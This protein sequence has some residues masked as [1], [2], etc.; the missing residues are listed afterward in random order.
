[1]SD[2]RISNVLTSEH[3]SALSLLEEVRDYMLRLPVVP[4]TRNLCVKISRH[5]ES[6]GATAIRKRSDDERG[7]VAY[8]AAGV[9]LLVANLSGQ[10]L[11]VKSP[12]AGALDEIESRRL[13]DMLTQGLVLELQSK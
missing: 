3:T 2:S 5:L 12:F 11:S 7:G 1:M 13:L 6:P 10:M 9:P 4:S 8:S